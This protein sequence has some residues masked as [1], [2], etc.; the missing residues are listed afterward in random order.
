MAVYGCL[1]AQCAGFR[2]IGWHRGR[3]RRRYLHDRAV[4]TRRVDELWRGFAHVAGNRGDVSPVSRR[5]SSANSVAFYTRDACTFLGA[6]PLPQ[7]LRG[8]GAGG[9]SPHSRSGR[10]TLLRSHVSPV[11]VRRLCLLLGMATAVAFVWLLAAGAA[12]S[13]ATYPGENPGG[14]ETPQ[15]STPSTTTPSTNPAPTTPPAD[16][17]ATPAP[18]A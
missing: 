14:T 16:S 4:L 5:I 10:R 17:T 15:S 8:G 13:F 7:S 1:R 9:G 3:V 2:P 12:N 18:P 11:P 6:R